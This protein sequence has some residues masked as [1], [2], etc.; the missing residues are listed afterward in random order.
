MLKNVLIALICLLAA[1]AAI[2]QFVPKPKPT[3]L[4]KAQKIL[5]NTPIVDTHI[6]F[7]WSLVENN[8]WYTPNYTALS[9]EHPKG[10]FDFKRAKQGGLYGAFMSIYIPSK[11]QKQ[12]PE[13]PK[14]V[15][16]SLIN[17]IHAVAKDHPAQ[18]A[19]AMR[20]D[21]V[22]ANF[23][24]GI[25]SLPMGM[26]NGAPMARLEDVAYF[27]Q[28]GI[29]Y[30]TLTHARDNHISDS[31]YDTTRTHGG[32]SPYGRAVVREMNR[33]GIMVD[34]S[35]LS[36]DAI[37]DVL[38]EAKKPLVASHSACRHFTPGLQRNLPDTLLRAVAKTNGV[39]QVPFSHYFL[40]ADA[41]K[42][43]NEAEDRMKKQG[44]DEKAPEAR[45]FMRKELQNMG[46]SVRDVADQI[47]YIRRVVGIDH[48]GFGSDFD[49]VGLALP[50]D[51]AD[52]SMYPNLIA[53]LLR[54]GYSKKD[55]QKICYGN[56]IRVWK[57][58]E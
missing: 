35:H 48:V 50:L 41:R 26:E 40:S 33:V 9:L 31:S 13:R 23:K 58:N 36:D 28:R 47:D 4:K 17:L 29:R 37:W 52:V 46:T 22:E 24:K 7:P 27:H 3:L 42:K 2:A 38:E 54:R 44:I 56:L 14:E 21:D 57:A 18:F 25:V 12:G 10:D 45:F 39:V 15:A 30:V 55:I 49:G 6:D 5:K 11:Y 53:E 16:D 8:E 19:L 20:A 1:Q 51:L 32:L 34:V 43:F